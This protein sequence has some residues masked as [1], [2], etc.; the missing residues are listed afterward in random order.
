M[1]LVC[2]AIWRSRSANSRR[3]R[4]FSCF[5]RSSASLRRRRL[6]REIGEGPSPRFVTASLRVDFLKPTPLGPELEA[7]GRIKERS[8]RKAIVEVTVSADGI[9]TARGEV[10]AVAMPSTMT[11]R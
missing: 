2:S 5:R 11:Q 4:S 6:G 9:V 10:V 3:K 8:D 7:R 1:R